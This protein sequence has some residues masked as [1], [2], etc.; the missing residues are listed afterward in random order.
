VITS[1]DETVTESTTAPARTGAR[2]AAFKAVRPLSMLFLLL[3]VVQIFL[4]GLGVFSLDGE[5]LGTAGESAFD[6]HRINGNIM[7]AVALV[8]LIA[9]LVARP[10]RRAIILAVTLLVIVAVLQSALAAL[11][12]DT[13]LFG[14]LHALFGIGALA[15]ASVLMA[16]GRRAQG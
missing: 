3:G 10:G 11:G 12:M 13:P 16:D 7:A 5:K 4:A 1:G 9:V 2:G 14:G 6:P 8:I 15:L